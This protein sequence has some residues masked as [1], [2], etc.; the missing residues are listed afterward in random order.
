MQPRT[1]VVPGLFRM[2]LTEAQALVKSGD[3]PE[4]DFLVFAGR[5]VWRAGQLQKELDRG[6]TWTMA[7]VDRR[8]LIR[9]LRG[10]KPAASDPVTSDGIAEWQR[11]YSV[12]N[13]G[14]D[15]ASKERAH[16]DEVLRQWVRRYL[17][18]LRGDVYQLAN[19]SYLLARPPGEGLSVEADFQRA[20]AMAE[21]RAGDVLRA[22]ATDWLL[23]SPEGCDAAPAAPAWRPVP[24]CPLQGGARPT[25]V[26]K[27]Q[28]RG[29]QGEGE[30]TDVIFIARGPAQVLPLVALLAQGSPPDSGRGHSLGWILE[31]EGSMQVLQRGFGMYRV[32]QAY[33]SPESPTILFNRFIPIH[34]NHMRW[35]RGSP[36]LCSCS[37]GRRR[38]RPTSTTRRSCDLSV[39]H[40]RI[41]A[42][43]VARGDLQGYR[44]GMGRQGTDFRMSM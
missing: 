20:A 5:C 23:G 28:V 34:P 9:E 4:E 19:R 2:N 31:Q 29:W 32:F 16:A 12:V 18:A 3:A 15:Q 7:A 11:L 36:C 14:R 41:S 8:T 26:G 39:A 38:S 43:V 37:M 13:P 24:C 33:F 1:E 21:I 17:L 40:G 35:A 10:N 30:G 25:S 22:S 6:D 27:A 44:A 42:P